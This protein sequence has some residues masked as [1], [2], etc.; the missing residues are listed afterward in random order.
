MLLRFYFKIT[1]IGHLTVMDKTEDFS[2][3]RQPH[4]PFQEPAAIRNSTC[5]FQ[6]ICSVV[7]CFVCLLRLLVTLLM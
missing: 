5:N 1:D 7:F 4:M 2:S 3:Y 6:F